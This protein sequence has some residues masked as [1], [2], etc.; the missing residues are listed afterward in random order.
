[1]IAR[2]HKTSGQDGYVT[3]YTGPMMSGK[4]SAMY[5]SVERYFLAGRNCIIVKYTKDIRFN[6]LMKSGGIVNH[7]GNELDRVKTISCE[8]VLTSILNDLTSIDVIG[9][10]EVQFYRDAPEIVNKLALSG[11]IVFLAGLDTDFRGIIFNRMAEVMAISDCV[12]KLNAVCSCG[13]DAS[14]TKRTTDDT[15]IE[16]IGGND[17]YQA[18][19]RGCFHKKH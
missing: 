2:V 14:F 1:M 7:A 15:D 6:H 19:C 9:I 10:D 13:K 16:L 17:K 4:T 5:H 12:Y 11:K 18:T 3:L 8:G